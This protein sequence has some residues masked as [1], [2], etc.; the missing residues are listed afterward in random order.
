MVLQEL[1]N[2]AGWTLTTGPVSATTANK[3]GRALI[4]TWLR[5][6]RQEYGL[7]PPRDLLVRISDA[8]QLHTLDETE[9]PE[10]KATTTP[11]GMGWTE[12]ARERIPELREQGMSY[13]EAQ[14]Q[15]GEEFRSRE[16]N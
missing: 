13:N 7:P 11:E 9:D 12:Y 3:P 5:L 16:E 10:P 8:V 1:K 14:K 4:D 6:Y 2:R 15:A